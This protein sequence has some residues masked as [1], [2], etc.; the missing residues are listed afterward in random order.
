MKLKGQNEMLPTKNLLS[1]YWEFIGISKKTKANFAEKLKSVAKEIE[2]EGIS[3]CHP[4]CCPV[5]SSWSI[6]G[7]IIDLKLLNKSKSRVSEVVVKEIKVWQQLKCG[8]HLQIHTDGSKD[9]ESGK[10]AVGISIPEVSYKKGYRVSDNVS[11]H[12]RNG[13]RSV[14]IRMG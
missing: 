8:D 7:P 1:E 3:V 12:S 2:I 6:P 10:V 13:G 5:V 14:V 11:L 9:H 4:V